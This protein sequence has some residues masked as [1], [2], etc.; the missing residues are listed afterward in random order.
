MARSAAQAGVSISPE[1]LPPE[2]REALEAVLAKAQA[3]GREPTLEDLPPQVQQA[4][5]HVAQ[6]LAQAAEDPQQ[7]LVEQVREAAL[8]VQAGQMDREALLQQLDQV[9]AQI[10]ANEAPGSPWMEAAGFVLAVAAHLRGQE[11]PPV[12]ARYAEE[13]AALQ[14]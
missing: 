11:P 6:Q 12:P 8:A 7:A 4:L 5:A 3:E 1:A 10:Q 9:A 2:L 14:G 13:F